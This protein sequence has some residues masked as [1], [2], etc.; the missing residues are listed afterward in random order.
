MHP[1][2][3]SRR[4]VLRSWLLSLTMPALQGAAGFTSP[5]AMCNAWST[6]PSYADK[7]R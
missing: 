2:A 3:R 1:T 5:L 7:P 6:A 4:R